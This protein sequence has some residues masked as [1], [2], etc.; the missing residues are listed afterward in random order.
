MRRP[1]AERACPGNFFR[2]R[3][4]LSEEQRGER[5]AWWLQPLI[6]ESLS[7]VEKAF[8]F[9]MR[10]SVGY[11]EKGRTKGRTGGRRL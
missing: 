4:S 2:P 1:R 5:L 3:Y 7:N 9:L 11:L 10:T 6:Q 8:G